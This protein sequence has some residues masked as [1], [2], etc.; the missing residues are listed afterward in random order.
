MTA[1]L[2]FLHEAAGA[3]DVDRHAVH[4][5]IT[6]YRHFRCL[7]PAAALFLRLV[8]GPYLSCSDDFSRAWSIAGG[9]TAAQRQSR[10]DCG[11]SKGKA[12][13]LGRS[14]PLTAIIEGLCP[15]SPL[16]KLACPARPRSGSPSSRIPGK[17]SAGLISLISQQQSAVRLKVPACVPAPGPNRFRPRAF[18]F[19]L[20]TVAAGPGH[21][22]LV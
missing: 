13:K 7:M 10:P 19:N 8:V 15:P 20:C 6:L 16:P 9:E 14:F 3:L 21:P 2:D 4:E 18:R 1:A 12:A 11:I 17:D 22:G 5:H